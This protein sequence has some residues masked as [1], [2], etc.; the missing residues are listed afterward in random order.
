MS[1][2]APQGDEALPNPIPKEINTKETRF[3]RKTEF[4]YD[5]HRGMAGLVALNLPYRLLLI[6]EHRRPR[7]G[8]VFLIYFKILPLRYLFHNHHIAAAAA[9]HL[10]RVHFFRF[11]RGNHKPARRG[12]AG[13]IA[14]LVHAVP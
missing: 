5:A 13:D 10:R 8:G 11:G 3:L 6:T 1:S 12:G 14:V 7:D 4:L 9:E 2:E